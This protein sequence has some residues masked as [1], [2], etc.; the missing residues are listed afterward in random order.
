LIRRPAGHGFTRHPAGGPQ[1]IDPTERRIY[2]DLPGLPAGKNG[3]ADPPDGLLC[4]P[5]C[6][7]AGRPPPAG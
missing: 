4:R 1:D 3:S 5:S 7:P 2:A 6:L